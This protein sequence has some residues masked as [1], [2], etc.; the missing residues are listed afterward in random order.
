MAVNS[1]VVIIA[2]RYY[3]TRLLMVRTNVNSMTSVLYLLC[4]KVLTWTLR[5]GQMRFPFSGVLELL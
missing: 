4:T 3:M 2:V 5:V 1:Y